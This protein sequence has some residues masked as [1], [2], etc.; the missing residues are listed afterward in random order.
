MGMNIETF[1][2]ENQEI[3]D[4]VRRSLL[5]IHGRGCSDK[6]VRGAF[7]VALLIVDVFQEV[8][9]KI[10]HQRYGCDKCKQK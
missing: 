10:N 5:G 4:F 6:Q 3:L 9:T 2:N 7:A 1:L 8:I